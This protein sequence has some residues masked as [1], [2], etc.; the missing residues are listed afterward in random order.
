MINSRGN[1][2]IKINS[3]NIL[4]Q[5]CFILKSSYIFKKLASTIFIEIMSKRSMS[6][7]NKL[8]WPLRF[9]LRSCRKDLCLLIINSRGYNKNQF[10]NIPLKFGLASRA[11]TVFLALRLDGLLNRVQ[12][13][14][15][16][17][18]TNAGRILP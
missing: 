12:K 5:F 1:L 13:N 10:W 6:V 18:V 9:L 15:Y 14:L 17:L 7:D 3:W 4:F 2:R 8:N 11:Y 16:N